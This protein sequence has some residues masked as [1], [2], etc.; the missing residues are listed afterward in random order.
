[1]NIPGKVRQQGKLI[2]NFFSMKV[3][4]KSPPLEL[5][6]GENFPNDK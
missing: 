4:D 6:G 5:G 1:M 3:I 2:D